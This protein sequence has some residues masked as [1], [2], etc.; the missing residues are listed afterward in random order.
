MRRPMRRRPHQHERRKQQAGVDAPPDQA[1]GT[2]KTL[3]RVRRA[4]GNSIPDAST[5]QTTAVRLLARPSTSAT[6]ET[7]QAVT[8]AAVAAAAAA[9]MDVSGRKPA[10]VVS[11]AGAP[12]TT[13]SRAQRKRAKMRERKREQQNRKGGGAGARAA[14][15]TAHERAA[16][17]GHRGGPSRRE[18]LAAG[19][20]RDV[21]SA[22]EPHGAASGLSAGARSFVP[23]LS[24]TP[25][26]EA[27][28]VAFG[29]GV[30]GSAMKPV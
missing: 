25:P 27:P 1:S 11:S 29:W 23:S 28:P 5:D 30:G 26:P 20:D 10:A 24:S 19:A 17:A 7:S 14:R 6:P 22:G 4:R 18:L 3:Q 21:L 9:A 2:I 13:M 8:S 15:S 16:G 12:K